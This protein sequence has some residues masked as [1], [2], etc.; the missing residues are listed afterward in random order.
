MVNPG[1]NVVALTDARPAYM[2]D[3][4]SVYSTTAGELVDVHQYVFQD[5][6]KP[7]RT[8]PVAVRETKVENGCVLRLRTASGDER[9]YRPIVRTPEGGLRPA[10]Q[11][12]FF[13]ADAIKTWRTIVEFVQVFYSEGDAGVVPARQAALNSFTA[14]E[15]VRADAAVILRQFARLERERDLASALADKALAMLKPDGEIGRALPSMLPELTAQ[16]RSLVAMQPE[17]EALMLRLADAAAALGYKLILKDEPVNHFDGSNTVP[18]TLARGQLYRTQQHTTTWST[19]R[20]ERSHYTR[21]FWGRKKWHYQTVRE[22]HRRS[23]TYYEWVAV[24]Y[25]PWV[26]A[27]EALRGEGYQVFLLRPSS[28]GMATPEGVP[29]SEVHQRCA[30]SEAF[31]SR[32]VVGVPFY[33]E[34]IIGERMMIGYQLVFRP[35]APLVNEHFPEIATDE[36]LAY[37]VA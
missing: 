8:A 28:D 31:R 29:L 24:D 37:R 11:G 19:S 22:K 1:D 4:S 7:F 20:Q 18:V 32:C 10:E 33:E 36:K 12:K 34:T 15:V 14:V 35:E 30:D 27:S 26:E 17:V 5:R 21:N 16:Y 6:S 9:W 23:F 3:G 2:H 25:D 13:A